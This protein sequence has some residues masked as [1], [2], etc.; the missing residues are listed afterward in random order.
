[1]VDRVADARTEMIDAAE[2]IVAERGV[3]AMSLR[4]VQ[5]ASGQRNKS[6][7]QYH[8]GSREGLIEAVV[9]ERMGPINARRQDLLAALPDQ[10]SVRDVVH[11]LVEPLAGAVLGDAGSCWARFLFQS[12]ADPGLHDVVRRSFEAS[13]YRKVRDLLGA[14]LTDLPEPV[15]RIRMDQAVGLVVMSLA[16]AEAAVSTGNAPALPARAR[17]VDLVD[18]AA[19]LLT[20]PCSSATIELAGPTARRA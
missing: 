12:W 3:P 13:S 16:A 20:A 5:A 15:R 11:A 14:A 18:T 19:A 8:F 2:R 4:E 7:A 6:A 10:P 17:I 1:M 9:R